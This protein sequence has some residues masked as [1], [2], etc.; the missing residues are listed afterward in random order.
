M[1]SKYTAY[2]YNINMTR[3]YSCL[4][5]IFHIKCLFIFVFKLYSYIINFGTGLQPPRFSTEK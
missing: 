1:I 3:E 4:Y 2:M 5:C